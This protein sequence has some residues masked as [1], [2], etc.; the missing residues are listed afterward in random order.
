MYLADGYD[1]TRVVKYDMNGKKLMQWGQKGT[2][3]NEKR[4]GYFNSVHGIAVDPT[5][6][7]VFVNDR[8]NGRV[9]VF[10]ENGKYLDEWN[11]GPRPPMDIHSFIV[12]SVRS[13]ISERAFLTSYPVQ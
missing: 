12:T 5:T 7:R 6:R 1:G 9:Q 4:P 11:F 2:P 8:T 13:R 3:P 10:D